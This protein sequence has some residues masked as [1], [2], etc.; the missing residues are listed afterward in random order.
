MLDLLGVPH[1]AVE[2]HVDLGRVRQHRV[3]LEHVAVD[4]ELD[5]GEVVQHP[6]EPLAHDV[7]AQHRVVDG[8]EG[9]RRLLGLD[10]VDVLDQ[11]ALGRVMVMRR[12]YGR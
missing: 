10:P 7:R 8:L 9:D 4:L 12:L 2:A 11:A 6:T 5:P 3:Q 1:V